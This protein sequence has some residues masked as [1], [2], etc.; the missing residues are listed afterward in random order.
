MKLRKNSAFTLIELLVVISII[1]IIAALAMPSFSSFLLKGKMTQQMSNGLNIFKAMGNYASDPNKDEF[2]A[3]TDTDDPSTL[4]Q[5]SNDAFEILLKNGMLDDKKVFF[6]QN[7]AWCQRTVQNETTSKQVQQ[8]END[9]CYVVG[10]KWSSKDSKWP[11]LANAFQPGST[12]YVKDQGQKGGAWKGT[13]AV[14]IWAGGN[15]EVVD[16]KEQ[17]STYFIKRTDKPTADAFVKEG[18]WLSGDKVKVLYP[19]G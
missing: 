14:V 11:L 7:S 6:N 19:E 10:I 2:P 16:T 4:V 18:E 8:G 13:R 17:G 15:G 3:Y 5:N 9:W 12:T 1:A